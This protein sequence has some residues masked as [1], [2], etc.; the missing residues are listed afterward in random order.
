MQLSAELHD[1]AL[2]ILIRTS[3]EAVDQLLTSR[4]SSSLGLV[5]GSDLCGRRTLH[6][7]S[8]DVIASMLGS[9]LAPRPAVAVIVVS[10]DSACFAAWESMR[11]T[12]CR[13]WLRGLFYSNDGRVRNESVVIAVKK[14][15]RIAAVNTLCMH[16]NRRYAVMITACMQLADPTTYILDSR[17][18]TAGRKLC[19]KRYT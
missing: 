4:T 19:R 1:E 17:D 18:L 3:P 15:K 7:V 16:L 10:A 2:R 9:L 5:I 14:S 13:L 12:R 8:V 6:Y 11:L